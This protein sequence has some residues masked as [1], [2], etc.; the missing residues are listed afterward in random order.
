MVLEFTGLKMELGFRLLIFCKISDV[1]G[2]SKNLLC[3]FV[4]RASVP[5]APLCHL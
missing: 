5:I 4:L 2:I 1:E 3:S